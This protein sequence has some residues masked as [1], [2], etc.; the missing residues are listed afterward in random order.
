[1]KTTPLKESSTDTFT[2]TNDWYIP[3]QHNT[4]KFI[5]SR[6][7]INQ[8]T[9][10]KIK[11]LPHSKQKSQLLSPTNKSHL[12]AERKNI[13][14]DWLKNK[15]NSKLDS[16]PIVEN[17]KHQ[18]SLLSSPTNK[19][20]TPATTNNNNTISSSN[21]FNSSNRSKTFNTG[22]IERENSIDSHTNNMSLAEQNIYRQTGV[23]EKLL[24]ELKKLIDNQFRVSNCILEVVELVKAI[25]LMTLDIVEGIYGYS[26]VDINSGSAN[27]ISI[28]NGSSGNGKNKRIKRPI[29]VS[30]P[31]LFR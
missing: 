20:N 11:N 17:N 5:K 22:S 30:L 15:L 4:S 18:N 23:R 21:G 3:V 2:H 8:L 31:F 16:Y 13:S 6:N 10:Y 24:T 25:R 7:P 9:N 29:A 14:I 26:G 12:T 1:M 27:D 28:K 19:Y